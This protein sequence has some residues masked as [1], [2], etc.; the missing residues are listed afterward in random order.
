MPRPTIWRDSRPRSTTPPAEMTVRAMPTS[1][2]V[3][4][5]FAAEPGCGVMRAWKST[6]GAA[7]TQGS[8]LLMAQLVDRVADVPVL[9]R[10]VAED[11]VTGAQLR[12]VEDRST[13]SEHPYVPV[14]L[15]DEV[16]RAPIRCDG[17]DGQQRAGLN[18]R[19][20]DG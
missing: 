19:P 5:S 14:V 16:R 9:G 12:R 6:T 7:S 4:S 15:H 17:V 10:Q 13:G 20:P 11:P 3:A 1:S 18:L 8:S 2:M